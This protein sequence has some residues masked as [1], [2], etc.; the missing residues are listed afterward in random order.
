MD[1]SEV[2]DIKST[3][4]LRYKNASVLGPKGTL[5]QTFRNPQGS[6][7]KLGGGG[8]D[9]QLAQIFFLLP[10]CASWIFCGKL[11]MFYFAFPLCQ[12]SPYNIWQGTLSLLP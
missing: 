5:V 4:A 10:S 11:K 12:N 1:G 2:V 7:N 6:F 9:F 3:L 8:G